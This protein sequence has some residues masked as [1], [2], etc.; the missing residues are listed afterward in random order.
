MTRRARLA[1]LR[2]RPFFGPACENVS[3]APNRLQNLGR[4]LQQQTIADQG[5]PCTNGEISHSAGWGTSA[6]I[7]GVVGTGQ[8]CEWTITA[9]ATGIAANPTIT[10]TLTNALPSASTVCEMRM[11]GGTGTATLIDQTT[12][13]ASAPVFTFGGTPVA[14]STYKIVR[15]CGP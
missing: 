5:N 10:D 3:V 6:S 13:S 14:G 2:G 11:A 9:N 15:R 4:R 12:L 7:T 1:R 8:T